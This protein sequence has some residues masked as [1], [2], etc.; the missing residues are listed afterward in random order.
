MASLCGPASDRLFMLLN[1]VGYDKSLASGKPLSYG[2]VWNLEVVTVVSQFS[3]PTDKLCLVVRQSV[4][5]RMYGF[6]QKVH[7]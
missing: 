4:V 2:K 6:T 7:I 3:D 1:S 5:L